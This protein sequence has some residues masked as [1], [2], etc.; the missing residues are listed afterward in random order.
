M[1]ARAYQ[2]LTLEPNLLRLV[3]RTEA[4]MAILLID[5]EN[6]ASRSNASAS[7]FDET[8]QL[9][10]RLN[11]GKFTMSPQHPTLHDRQTTVFFSGVDFA[12]VLNHHP[13]RLRFWT[14]SKRLSWLMSGS[15][16]W[17]QR[18]AIQRS[19]EGMGW[20]AFLSSARIWGV[21]A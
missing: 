14:A 17:R 13:I 19:F 6:R 11:R 2:L 9:T 15:R 21:M 10:N 5:R 1:A 8:F 18:A 3:F 12:R 20:P 16:C 4:E 7:Q